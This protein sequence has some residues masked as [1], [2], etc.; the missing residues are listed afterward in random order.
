M[1]PGGRV[2]IKVNGVEV[3]ITKAILFINFLPFI[4]IT[5]FR[6][7]QDSQTS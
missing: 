5:D 2:E 1:G 7:V 3:G 4:H 6:Q